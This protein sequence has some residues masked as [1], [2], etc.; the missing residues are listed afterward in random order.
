MNQGKRLLFYIVLNILV[1]ACTI[2]AVLWFWDRPHH[3]ALASLGGMFAQPASQAPVPP[4]SD[5]N[6]AGHRSGSRCTP[7]RC[8]SGE[9]ARLVL[10]DNVFGVGN[11]KDE[12][13]LLKRPV[14]AISP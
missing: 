11:L 8:D 3:P 2:L 9:P 5:P 4:V 6:C 1:S 13:V 10:I 12:Y 14:R 7:A